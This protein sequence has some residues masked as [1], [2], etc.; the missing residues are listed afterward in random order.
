VSGPRTT[1]GQSWATTD[2]H[3]PYSAI[4]RGNL[5]VAE[6]EARDLALNLDDALELTALV[7]LRDRDRGRRYSLRC[8]RRWLNETKPTIEGAA[9]VTSCLAALGAPEHRATLE[10]LRTRR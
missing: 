8:L 1:R 6:F 3:E 7:V 4:E 9:I 2:T 5:V 10:T